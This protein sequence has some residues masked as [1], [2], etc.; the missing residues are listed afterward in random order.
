MYRKYLLLLIIPLLLLS[1]RTEEPN[2]EGLFR[3][4]MWYEA[5]AE[6]TMNLHDAEIILNGNRKEIHVT[7]IG[8][9]DILDI[10]DEVPE[11]INLR[12]EGK[13]MIIVVSP[14]EGDQERSH[15]IN[16]IVYRGNYYQTGFIKILQKPLTRQDLEYTESKAIKSYLSKFDVIDELPSLS[17]IS[18]GSVGPFYKVSPEG[19][20]YMQVVNMGDGEKAKEGDKIYFRYKRY[21]LLSYYEDKRLPAAEDNFSNGQPHQYFIVGAEDETTTQYGTA[22]PLPMELGLP[23][24]AE[25][26]LVVASSAGLK[27]EKDLVIPYLYNIKYYTEQY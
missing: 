24:G 12:I 16:F 15:T 20:V 26:N 27:A 18:T 21:N 22:L 4:T 1:C 7:L 13:N 14:L 11:W 6:T 10:L 5:P 23:I 2:P 9:F 17:E 3:M 25:V 19:N 8:E